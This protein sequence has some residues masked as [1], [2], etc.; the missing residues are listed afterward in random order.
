MKILTYGLLA[1]V[2]LVVPIIAQHMPREHASDVRSAV[3]S[4]DS[5]MLTFSSGGTPYGDCMAGKGAWPNHNNGWC[6]VCYATEQGDALK[7]PA[8]F[9]SKYVTGEATVKGRVTG[10]Q[11]GR[12]LEHARVTI[13][14]PDTSSFREAFT[15]VEG[16]YQFDSL[17]AGT[18]RIG[19]SS[20]LYEY[21]ERSAQ[22]NDVSIVDFLL[23][24]DTAKGR[25]DILVDPGVRLGGTNSAV[26]LPDGR[27]F[28][29][30]DT[31][32]PVIFD[33]RTNIATQGPQSPNIQGCHAVRLLQDGRMIFVGGTDRE[34]YGP[35]TKQVKT[36]DPVGNVWQ[37]QSSLVDERWYPSMTQLPDGELIAIG[38]GG[39]D[40]PVRVK[41][42]ETMD[43]ATL[44][45][46]S[47]GDILIGNEVSP[48]ALLYTGEV[49]MTHRPPQLYDP[50]TRQWRSA[51]DF[52][53]GNRM[54][55]GDHS[56]HEI[57]ML[58][59]GKVLAIGYKSFTSGVYE[60]IVEIYN[61]MLD[62]WSL[63]KMF[64]PARSRA[65]I[66]M[67]P[68]KT[69]LVIGGYKEDA[70]D[71]TPTNQWGYMKLTDQYDPGHDS[72]RRLADLN[73]AREYHTTSILIP[74]GRIIT[75]GGEGEPGNEPSQS[76]VEGFSP[77]YLFR[78]MR[79][80]IRSLSDTV[81]RRGEMVGFMIARTTEPTSVILIGTSARTHF[82]ESGNL[83][84]IELEFEQSG[85]SV[86][87]RLPTDRNILPVGYYMLFAMVDDIPS[88]GRIVRVDMA[89]SGG[90]RSE[91]QGRARNIH[92]YPN[93]MQDV[94][95]L[96]F[97][98]P[99]RAS[100]T[101]RVL[102]LVGREVAIFEMG[103]REAGMYQERWDG[104]D[105]SN[106]IYFCEL[107][108]GAAKSVVPVMLVR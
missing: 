64:A 76:L 69:V 104:S 52:V 16:Y 62:V 37:I 102:N 53:Q 68:D 40:N 58:P 83:R 60:S 47:A 24:P 91:D 71:A 100:A 108:V 70:T 32:D 51:A 10:G 44:T 39:P 73:I 31:R 103:E 50:V 96:E 84:Y 3:G 12:G 29:C 57:V 98:L 75:V 20:R 80:E 93:P 9:P 25:W 33:P 41:T 81:L 106:G 28:Y 15:D 42:S 45:W 36:L 7:P 4:V 74:D 8:S 105:L 97:L 72:W 35:G 101:L 21:V 94:A 59:D 88:V 19:V 89:A 92:V 6:H 2:I 27:I 107:R 18:Y 17:M 78:G 43:P 5:F 86:I 22:I 1:L 46:R 61:P 99:Q 63:G 95:T 67:L 11:S 82:M 38:G 49:L 30:H 85:D 26:L 13:F 56:D 79:P 77:P 34:V 48:I 54:P 87:A 14:S 65:S 66:A 90:T 23:G 55:N